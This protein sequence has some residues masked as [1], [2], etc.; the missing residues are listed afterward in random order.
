LI[1]LRATARIQPDISVAFMM[2]VSFQRGAS[3]VACFLGGIGDKEAKSGY[4]QVEN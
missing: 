1:A 4:L 3:T 2:G